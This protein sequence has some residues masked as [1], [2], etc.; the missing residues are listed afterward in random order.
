MVEANQ[1][2]TKKKLMIFQWEGN[3]YGVMLDKLKSAQNNVV[4][5]KKIH[6]FFRGYKISR[7]T[8][9]IKLISGHYIP[10]HGVPKI[11]EVKIETNI[12]LPYLTEDKVIGHFNSIKKYQ[13]SFG[14]LL[15][16]I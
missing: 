13:T 7:N 10:T 1:N 14:L 8:N 11:E 5:I 9:C 12:N 6:P 15:D 2:M 16:D 3:S 4:N